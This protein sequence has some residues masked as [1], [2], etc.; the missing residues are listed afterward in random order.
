MSTSIIRRDP[1]RSVLFIHRLIQEEYRN[2][3]GIDRQYQSFLDASTLLRDAFPKLT[4]GQSM[5]PTWTDCKRYI[6]HVLILCAR[7]Q[8]CRF[9]PK[10]K[11]E[12]DDF[13]WLSTACGWYVNTDYLLSP[14]SFFFFTIKD[15]PLFTKPSSSILANYEVSSFQ[16]QVSHGSRCLA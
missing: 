14:V 4:L 15:T 13:L 9:Q 1:Q 8:E 16:P 7:W 3:M 10:L 2:Y 11:D 12:L 6:Q 5:R